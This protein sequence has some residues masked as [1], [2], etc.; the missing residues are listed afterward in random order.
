MNKLFALCIIASTAATTAFGA[1]A[2]QAQSSTFTTKQTSSEALG[3][4]RT[5]GTNFGGQM[6][7]GTSETVQADGKKWSGTHKCVGVTMPPNDS[8]Y[9]AR[10][11]CENTD[12]AGT[13]STIWGCTTPAKD[14]NEVYC[15]GWAFGKSGAY[16]NRRG[17]MT[18]VGAGGTG[19]GTALWGK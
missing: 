11:I 16:A 15:T 8:T 2:A 9:N 4:T 5:D 7:T 17:V 10:L 6:T 18:F 1:S 19:S 14:T 12:P 13:S 3:G